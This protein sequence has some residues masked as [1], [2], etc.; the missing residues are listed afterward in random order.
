[1]SRSTSLPLWYCRQMPGSKTSDVNHHG[2]MSDFVNQYCQDPPHYPYGTVGKCPEAK[3]Q[4]S[5]I[6]EK[7]QILSISNVK[8]HLTTPMVLS[9]NARKQNIRCQSSWKNVR[10]CQSLF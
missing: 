7:C 5:I 2:K 6:M 10:F 4:M 1:M 9:A 3:H 8:I